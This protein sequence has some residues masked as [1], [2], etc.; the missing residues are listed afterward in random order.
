M[1]IK[2]STYANSPYSMEFLTPDTSIRAISYFNKVK[3]NILVTVQLVKHVTINIEIIN[4]SEI[5]P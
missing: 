1:P 4:L 2:E 5:L 3:F